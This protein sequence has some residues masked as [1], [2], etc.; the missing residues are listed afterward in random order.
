M[1]FARYCWLVV[2]KA[3]SR[4]EED[5]RIFGRSPIC[6]SLEP[7]A[8]FD[9]LRCVRIPQVTY[10]CSEFAGSL[11]ESFRQ[12][13]QNLHKQHN[14]WLRHP[15]LFSVVV[16][17]MDTTASSLHYHPFGTNLGSW[18][19]SYLA[20]IAALDQVRV[21]LLFPNSRA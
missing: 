14:T 2:T 5:A 21:N 12:S 8:S 1:D 20:Y 13:P 6:K 15:H 17:N 18:Q 7:P 4:E 9:V 19:T 3:S 10:V 16:L 11:S